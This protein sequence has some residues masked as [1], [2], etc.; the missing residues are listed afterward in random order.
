[1]LPACPILGFTISEYIIKM[2]GVLTQSGFYSPS[3]FK[4]IFE[5]HKFKGISPNS[6]I[7]KEFLQALHRA[8]SGSYK[9]P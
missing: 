9:T 3:V 4:C 8:G 5:K 6:L 7:K 1:M 2:K